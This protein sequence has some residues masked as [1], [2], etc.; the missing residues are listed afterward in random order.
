[1]LSSRRR[2]S[3]RCRTRPG[4]GLAAL[5]AFLLLLVA[6]AL[7]GACTGREPGSSPG[8]PEA[9]TDPGET[10]GEA[11]AGDE[12]ASGE[13][14]VPPPVGGDR[15]A[16]LEAAAR[17]VA[18]LL[19]R[20][21]FAALARLVHP[22]R[23]LVVSPYGYVD[24]DEA[25]RLS[26]EEVATAGE[27]PTVRTWGHADGTGEPLELAFPEYFERYVYD[28]DF[29]SAPGVAVDRRLGQGNTVSNL[30]EAFP[31]GSFVEF[32][33]PGFEERYQ[34]M[35]WRSLRL[36]FSPVDGRWW[37]VGVVHD[38]WTI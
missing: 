10:G 8:T 2:G 12:T 36:V 6:G 38:E 28:A 34:G 1:M 33:F 24:L 17:E 21:D 18:G 26:Q 27:D 14:T 25:V 19:A 32:H 16:T 37:L 4:R 20:R 29:A 15:E 9:V 11:A 7:T 3:R 30:D 31:D 23:G 13:L 5:G 35:D 22:E